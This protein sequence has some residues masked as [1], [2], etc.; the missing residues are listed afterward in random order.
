MVMKTKTANISPFISVNRQY[1]RKRSFSVVFY[2]IFNN[3]PD[4]STKLLLNQI[5]EIYIFQS[6]LKQNI[7]TALILRL[8]INRLIGLCLCHSILG[9]A[10]VQIDNENADK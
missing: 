9:T 8:S 3:M 7:F 1:D 4:P 2:G 6:N 5:C 10:F